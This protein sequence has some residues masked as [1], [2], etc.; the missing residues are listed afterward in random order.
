MYDSTCHLSMIL[1]EVFVFKTAINECPIVE[2]MCNKYKNSEG[3]CL[4]NINRGKE[5]KVF[6]GATKVSNPIINKSSEF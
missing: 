5:W 3:Y 2:K 1:V 6:E 4:Y